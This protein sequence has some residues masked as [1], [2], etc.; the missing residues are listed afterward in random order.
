VILLKDDLADERCFIAFRFGNGIVIL[1]QHNRFPVSRNDHID[2][3]RHRVGRCLLC[4]TRR[5]A[6]CGRR[7]DVRSLGWLLAGGGEQSGGEGN[8]ASSQT[9]PPQNRKEGQIEYIQVDGSCRR[10][11]EIVRVEFVLAAGALHPCGVRA[12]A[13]EFGG[14]VVNIPQRN[15]MLRIV[16]NGAEAFAAGLHGC[17]ITAGDVLP[18]PLRVS[19]IDDRTLLL[20]SYF[21]D[22]IQYVLP[23]PC[24]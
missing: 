15:G 9:L 17:E 21:V 18:M 10:Q 13:V 7:R 19:R 14:S 3:L 22:G 11:A 6:R 2:R 1:E 8:G 24:L 16:N 12:K 23:P 4:F 5:F 20:P